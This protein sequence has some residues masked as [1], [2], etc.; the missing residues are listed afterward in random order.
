MPEKIH[1]LKSQHEFESRLEHLITSRYSTVVRNNKTNHNLGRNF[2]DSFQVFWIF[3][4]QTRKGNHNSP[5]NSGLL[6]IKAWVCPYIKNNSVNKI[7]LKS[8]SWTFGG[9]KHLIGSTDKLDRPIISVKL[10]EQNGNHSLLKENKERV[11]VP[12]KTDMT[13]HHRNLTSRYTW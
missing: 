3:N 9:T 11:C 5:L 4:S 13:L 10:Y 7:T 6:L 2:G 12:P 1:C 8:E